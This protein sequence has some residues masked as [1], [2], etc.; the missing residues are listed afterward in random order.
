MNSQLTRDF[1]AYFVESRFVSIVFSAIVILLRVMMYLKGGL[2]EPVDFNYNISWNTIEQSL[3]AYPV[4]SF[5]GST[6]SVFIISFLVSELNIRYGI[7]RLRTSMPFYITLLL[8]SIHPAF[9]RL[10]PDLLALIFILWSLFPLLA[11]YQFQRSHR[12]AFQ[13]SA[14]LAIGSVFQIHT[15]L[16]LPLWLIG[17]K[18]LDSI[19]LRSIF[20]SL[21]G[22]II[23]YW[24]VFSLYVFGD[25]ISGFAD[26]FI[27]LIQIYDFTIVPSFSVPQW[28]FVGTLLLLVI[29]F[30]SADGKQIVR[31]RSFTKKV[32]FFNSFVLIFAVLLQIVYFTRT[33]LFL[34][35]T[36]ALFSMIISHFY[37]NSIRRVQVYSFFALLSL[38][39]LYYGINLLTDLSPF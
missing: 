7:I 17:L 14:L 33:L 26:P 12:Y 32:L 22:M 18:V 39:F 36:I 27:Q 23:V 31:E 28:G 35:V 25:N 6:L 4:L 30:L 3:Q 38:L 16:F 15:L 2:P 11:T 5:L 29:I 10:T 19:N 37:T 8:L 1:K 34:Y 20:A 9:L 13:F 21:F 24:I